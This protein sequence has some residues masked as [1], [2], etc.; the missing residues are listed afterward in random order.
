MII[1]DIHI[2]I[3]MLIIAVILGSVLLDTFS[4]THRTRTICLNL[5]EITI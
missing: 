2:L 4:I 3:K 5:S 1:M